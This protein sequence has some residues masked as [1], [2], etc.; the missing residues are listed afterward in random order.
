LNILFPSI[1][2]L[3]LMPTLWPAPGRCLE[4]AQ[5]F[6]LLPVTTA[7]YLWLELP[8][9]K[10]ESRQGEGAAHLPSAGFL[11]TVDLWSIA[12]NAACSR[13]SFFFEHV[14]EKRKPVSERTCDDMRRPEHAPIRLHQDVL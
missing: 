5:L 3:F 2:A 9:E 14:P 4:K 13:G 8:G 12:W 11:L 7:V 10:A 6:Y 1:S